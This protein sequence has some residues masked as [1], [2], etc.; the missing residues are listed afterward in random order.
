MEIS[1]DS[2]YNIGYIRLRDKVMNV[3]TISISDELNI[4]IDSDG[5]VYGIELLNAGEQL[6]VLQGKPF[7][8]INETE[9]KKTEIQVLY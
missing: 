7:T 5:K 3:K 6:G 8:F 2:K 4:D 9:N 1:Y